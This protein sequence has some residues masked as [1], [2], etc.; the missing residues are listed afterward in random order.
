M[1]NE[2]LKKLLRDVENATLADC[3]ST[4]AATIKSIRDYKVP[5]TPDNS[6]SRSL[7]AEECLDVLVQTLDKLAEKIKE[8]L[9]KSLESIKQEI[10]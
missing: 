10:K 5:L 4:L 1:E 9:N 2:L 3:F 7:T 6:G 8:D